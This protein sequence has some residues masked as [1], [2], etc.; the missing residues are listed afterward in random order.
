MYRNKK[1]G[2]LMGGPSAEREVSLKTGQAVV[3]ALRSKGYQVVEVDLNRETVQRLIDEQVEVVYNALH[4]K[5][6]EDGCV[7][8]L[9]E[10]LRIPYTGPGVAASAIG[11]DKVI[12]KRLFEAAGLNV[13]PYIIVNSVQAMGLAE[14][15]SPFGWPLVIKPATEGSSVG[16]AITTTAQELEKALEQAF[17]ADERVLLEKY[18]PGREITVAVMENEA[19]GLVEVRPLPQPDEKI[20][21]YDYKH[22]YTKGW[23]EYITRPEGLKPDAV[24]TVFG[25]AV[26]ANMAIG[27]EGVVRVDF[28]YDAHGVFWVLEVNTLPG[29]TELSL[30]PMVARDWRNIAFPDLVEQVLSTARLKVGA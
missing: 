12:S 5:W 9:L 26:A 3:K 10:L 28:I 22:K 15:G 16:I 2:V 29:L 14:M 11:M 30:V 23:T 6:G 8:G 13:P 1:V 18:I 20:T 4:G 25:L 24:N 21:F 7:Q 17:H 19:L 27:G